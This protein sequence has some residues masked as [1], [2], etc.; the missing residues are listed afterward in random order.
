VSWW[1]TPALPRESGPRALLGLHALWGTRAELVVGDADRIATASLL[2]RQVGARCMVLELGLDQV[3]RWTWFDRWAWHTLHSHGLIAAEAAATF[4]DRA[5]SIDPERVG[6]WPDEVATAPVDA[7]DPD[8]EILERACERS[9]ARQRGR[10]PRPAVFVD[11][12]GTLVREVGYLA[13]PTD[14]E[15]LPGVPEALRRL[16]AA[17]YAIVVV[18]NQSG[19]ARGLFPRARVYEIMGHLRRGLRSHGVELDGI[20]VCP[21]A[22]EDECPC[23]KPKPGLLERASEDLE[24]AL[25][26]SVIVGDKWIDVAAGHGAGTRGILV[27]SGYGRDQEREIVATLDERRPEAICDDLGAAADWILAA[28]L[29]QPEATRA[30]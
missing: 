14:L 1:G 28:E 21:H 7:G 5:P 4:R 13:N 9:L 11:R 12:D 3:A 16:Q 2:G 10:A 27:R 25:G 26:R 8:V 6:L 22:P 24:L 23:R 20:Y 18:S 17:G 30:G 15:I 29:D 19:V